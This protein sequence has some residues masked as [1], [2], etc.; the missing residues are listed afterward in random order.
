MRMTY[1]RV[2]IALCAVL[3]VFAC[4]NDNEPEE[5]PEEVSRPVDKSA[6][7]RATGSSGRDI[8]SNDEFTKIKVEIAFVTG[9]RPTQQAIDEFETYLR[10]HTFK[11]D[12]EMVFLELPSPEVEDFDIQA[13][14]DLELE[15]RTVFND[16]DTLGIY[17]YFA[18]AP[19][20]DD[21]EEEGLV[22]LGAV[23]RNTSMVIHEITIR[24]LAALSAQISNADIET[25]TINHEFGH[26]FGLVNLGTPP[27]NDHEDADAPNHCNVEGCLMRSELQFSNSN[28][29]R[30]SLTAADGRLKS[31]CSLTGHS[32][33]QLLESQ[34]SKGLINAVP[35]DAE[36]I[37]DL[38]SN[39]GR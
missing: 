15:N 12:I 28:S 10:T 14:A 23:Y 13:I 30:S 33:M 36:C 22:T 5:T 11:E 1:L 21:D 19:S 38:Q 16:G 8:L 37:L 35:L 2:W 27:V 24:R 7:L 9:F 3:L 29:G 25:A 18:D 17:I 34:S 20:E 31:A 39:G 4:S 32:V 26:L 6:N